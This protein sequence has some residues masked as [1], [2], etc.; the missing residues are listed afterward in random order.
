MYAAHPH[1]HPDSTNI[2]VTMNGSRLTFIQKTLVLYASVHCWCC[3]VVPLRWSWILFTNHSIVTIRILISATLRCL[4]LTFPTY[5]SLFLI[6][7]QRSAQVAFILTVI[8][9]FRHTGQTASAHQLFSAIKYLM[10]HSSSACLCS[11]AQFI[12]FTSQLT[13]WRVTKKTRQNKS[14]QGLLS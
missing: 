5:I 2:R 13:W 4:E 12:A 7:F 11:A 6:H 8:H 1:T 3:W 9:P 14:I 10:T